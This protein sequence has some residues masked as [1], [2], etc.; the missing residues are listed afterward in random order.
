MLLEG[1][2]L[3]VPLHV[4]LASGGLLCWLRS[5]AGG[6]QLK[7]L[8]LPLLLLLLE[9]LI[10]LLHYA[11]VLLNLQGY[12]FCSTF[13]E[14]SIATRTRLNHLRHTKSWHTTSLHHSLLTNK[15]VSRAFNLN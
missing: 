1:L 9:V 7:V 10:G 15:A 13:E 14:A 4:A 8:L 6:L 11:W 12:R 3:A 5:A 2:R